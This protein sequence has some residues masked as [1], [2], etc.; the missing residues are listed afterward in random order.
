MSHCLLTMKQHA[1]FCLFTS[2]IRD[3][4]T[5]ARSLGIKCGSLLDINSDIFSGA[6]FYQ[7]QTFT[8]SPRNQSCQSSYFW[9][10]LVLFFLQFP[11]RKWKI[12]RDQSRLTFLSCIVASPLYFV[13]VAKPCM[14]VLQHKPDRTAI[15]DHEAGKNS[16]Q[17]LPTFNNHEGIKISLLLQHL[18][19]L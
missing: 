19:S 5:K 4:T 13:L 18:Y 12:F 2:I 15:H 16:Y 17:Q 9:W 14:L 1:G 11:G 3:Q 6:K 8:I 7:Q 10:Q